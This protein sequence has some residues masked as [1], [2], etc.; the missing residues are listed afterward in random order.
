MI[1]DIEV[2]S[3]D[4]AGVFFL[5]GAVACVWHVV[6]DGFFASRITLKCSFHIQIFSSCY[7]GAADITAAVKFPLG[8]ATVAPVFVGTG[9][10]VI[11][12]LVAYALG[13]SEIYIILTSCR[14]HLCVCPE[15]VF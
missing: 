12:D 5:Q 4:I 10:A 1:V 9:N 11:T 6:E 15:I 8:Y 7:L 13:C 14:L 3:I 2:R